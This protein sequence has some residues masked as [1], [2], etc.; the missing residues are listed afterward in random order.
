MLVLALMVSPVGAAVCEVVCGSPSHAAAHAPVAAQTDADAHAH[1]DHHAHHASP[2]APMVPQASDADGRMHVPGP[3]CDP[4]LAIPG[5]VRSAFSGPDF[6]ATIVTH[7]AAVI[8][9][10]V[11]ARSRV[12]VSD[13]GPPDPP[14]SAP[15]PLRI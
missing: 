8:D 10:V 12:V 14:R 13:T 15:V 1:H 11:P 5:R 4:L 9:P 6:H 7:V 2:A 3:E